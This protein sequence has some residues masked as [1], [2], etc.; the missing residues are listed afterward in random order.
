[1]IEHLDFPLVIFS[2]CDMPKNPVKM[3]E[4]RADTAA[5]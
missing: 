4:Q 1:M 5:A 3:G 2:A